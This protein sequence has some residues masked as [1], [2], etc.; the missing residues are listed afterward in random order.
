MCDAWGQSNYRNRN[1]RRR[2]CNVARSASAVRLLARVVLT[3][4]FFDAPGRVDVSTA[5]GLFLLFALMTP[6]GLQ[7]H[8]IDLL[9]IDGT[10][11]VAHGLEK[12]CDA[13]VSRGAQH[14][15]RRSYD[16]P[17]CFFGE[18]IVGECDAV[19]LGEN[20]G[21][22]TIGRKLWHQCE[23]GNKASDVIIDGQG[24]LITGWIDR[25]AAAVVAP[26]TRISPEVAYGNPRAWHASIRGGRCAMAMDASIGA[27][28]NDLG[29]EACAP[30]LKLGSSFS[31]LG[32]VREPLRPV[33]EG[34][35]LG[36]GASLRET[37]C[38]SGAFG[39]SGAVAPVQYWRSRR[40]EPD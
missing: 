8:A 36:S 2:G 5:C 37:C 26:Y 40:L 12:R 16:E 30:N 31:S 27:D 4:A 9:Q 19:E 33:G 23:I 20:E 34:L 18:G 28:L 24:E 1:S 39:F 32:P 29:F 22:C 14:T 17:E 3:E 10:G 13:K 15:L 25:E 7:Q 6:V 21:Y 11:A 38:F 35:R